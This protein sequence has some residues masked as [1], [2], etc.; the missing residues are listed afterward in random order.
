MGAKEKKKHF[1]T[2]LQLLPQLPHYIGRTVNISNQVKKKIEQGLA[3]HLS[4]NVHGNVRA[5]FAVSFPGNKV[6]GSWKVGFSYTLA[7]AL[8]PSGPRTIVPVEEV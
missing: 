8:A 6:G 4:S 7:P 3:T 2:L 1:T 5:Y